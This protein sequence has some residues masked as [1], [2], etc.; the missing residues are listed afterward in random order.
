[1]ILIIQKK[2]DDILIFLNTYHELLSRFYLPD[3]IENNDKYYSLSD[4]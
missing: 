3:F 4:F 2:I 1:M